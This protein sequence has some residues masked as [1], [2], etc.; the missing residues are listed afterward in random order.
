MERVA[1]VLFRTLADKG[2]ETVFLLTGNGAMFINDAIAKEPRL[3]YVCARHEA[4][5]PMMAAAHSR[6]SGKIGVVSV[7][8]GPGAA[9]A[10]SGLAE[11]WV[12]SAPVVVIAGQSPTSELPVTQGLRTFGTAGIDIVSVVKPITKYAVTVTDPNRA[13]YELEKA[14]DI[15]TSGRPGPVWLDIPM[16][17]QS[18]LIDFDEVPRYEPSIRSEPHEIDEQVEAIISAINRSSRPLVVVGQGVKQSGATEELI[19]FLECSGLPFALTRLGQDV[20]PRT[21][22]LNLGSLGRRGAP[23]S[24]E[25]LERADLVLAIGARLATQFGG[26]NLEN[27]HSDAQVFVVDIDEPELKKFVDSRVHGVLADAGNFLRE[28]NRSEVRVDRNK[29]LPWVES[30]SKLLEGSVIPNVRKTSRPMDLY[31]FMSVLDT[32][33][34]EGQILVT[35]AGSN[36]Y[37]GGQVFMF[38]GNKIEVTSGTF[39]AMGTGIPLGIGAAVGG[40]G[41]QV[42]AITGDGSLE[43][44]IQELKTMSYYRLNMKLFVINNG[45]Y[46]SMRNWQD[47]FFEGR[48]IGSDDSTGAEGLHLES[49]AHAFGLPYRRLEDPKT[50]VKDLEEIMGVAEPIF[51]EVICDDRQE[52]YQPFV[53]TETSS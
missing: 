15:A 37:V 44:N 24:K 1:D 39:A 48:R 46:V 27:F 14:T 7:T 35:D 45:G 2:A 18:A 52:I 9:N 16:D 26:H 40:G 47:T 29:W 49:V 34:E 43:L 41:R 50:L 17:V 32:V 3:N 31:H 51:I 38:E 4:A 42:L 25:V 28:M 8:S 5:A 53:D 22:P 10:V 11:A 13:L 6:V 19:E 30:L 12:D 21:F 23:H 33:A 36:Y 20:L